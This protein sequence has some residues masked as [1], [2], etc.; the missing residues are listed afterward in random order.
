MAA[1][2]FAAATT[3]VLRKTASEASM[4]TILNSFLQSNS[5]QTSQSDLSG[6]DA[7]NASAAA[8]SAAATSLTNSRDLLRE[9][10]S[11]L[12]NTTMSTNQDSP[13][14][15]NLLRSFQQSA[16][17]TG[18][19]ELGL[20]AM[21]TS[22]HD[23]PTAGVSWA[24]GGDDDIHSAEMDELSDFDMSSHG[25]SSPHAPPSPL[26]SAMET[27]MLE[28]DPDVPS[29]LSVE[30]LALMESLP[31][32]PT[33]DETLLSP[34]SYE[35]LNQLGVQLAQEASTPVRRTRSQRPDTQAT[36]AMLSTPSMM[37]EDTFR[38]ST[39]PRT[40]IPTVDKEPLAT[41]A[42]RRP[43][44][45]EQTRQ[46]QELDVRKREL[47]QHLGTT[48]AAISDTLGVLFKVWKDGKMAGL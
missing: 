30:C 28:F 23:E 5:P 34:D 24:M 8:P 9:Y 6:Q 21:E 10:S 20:A 25:S 39:P 15:E 16:S 22:Q 14:L 44:K 43:T 36:L 7:S 17:S 33:L 45:R 38:P 31:P 32:I 3:A 42:R 37:V 35:A 11:S 41:K 26:Q 12:F 46:L 47:E 19:D 18:F 48:Q 1:L 13:S 27:A 4:S 40:T 2:P 29:S